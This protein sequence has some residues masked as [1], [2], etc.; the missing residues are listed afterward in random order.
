MYHVDGFSP[1]ILATG[2]EYKCERDRMNVMNDPTKL[3]W[4]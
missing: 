2:S 3:F 4:K 1:E